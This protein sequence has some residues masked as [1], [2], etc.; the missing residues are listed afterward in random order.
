MASK[1]AVLLG[2]GASYDLIGAGTAT[3]THDYRPPLTAEIF[4]CGPDSSIRPS[5]QAILETYQ[6][7]RRLAATIGISVRGGQSLEAV[8]RGLQDSCDPNT[9]RHFWD[10]PRY[11]QHLFGTIS[12]K[13]TTEPVNYTYLVHAVLTSGLEQVA[14]VTTNYD[15]FLESALTSVTETKFDSLARYVPNSKWMLIKL[16]GSVNWARPIRTRTMRGEVVEDYE[17]SGEVE[18]L[19]HFSHIEDRQYPA[20]VVPVDGKYGFLCPPGHVTAV[21]SVLASCDNFLIIGMSGRDQDLLDL[22][23]ESITTCTRLAVIG[24]ED[25]SSVLERFQKGINKFIGGTPQTVPPVVFSDGFSKFLRS[26][27]LDKFL[28]PIR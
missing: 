27:M 11:L 12:D 2:A 17:F 14:F 15:L 19:G 26:G 9:K 18:F 20:V 6:G 13:Y 24:G 1:L 4:G 8:L 5:F 10:I 7:A 16:H 28:K 3:V 23:Q 21:K 25:T 22:L